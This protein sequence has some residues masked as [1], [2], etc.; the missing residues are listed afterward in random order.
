MSNNCFI[1]FKNKKIEFIFENLEPSYNEIF[2]SLIFELSVRIENNDDHLEIRAINVEANVSLNEGSEEFFVGYTKSS[3]LHKWRDKSRLSLKMNID[4]Y[5]LS[6]IEKKR[7]GKDLSFNLGIQFYAFD[8]DINNIGFYNRAISYI[9]IPQSTWINKIL[10]KLNYK[11]VVLIELPK[12]EFPQLSMIIEQFDETWKKYSSNNID[13]TLT[14]CRKILEYVSTYIRKKGFK[15]KKE[16]EENGIKTKKTVT[17]WNKFFNDDLKGDVIGTLFQ[18]IIGFNS[19][20]A[21]SSNI[22][23][24]PN[25]AYFSLIQTHALVYYIISQLKIRE[26]NH[27][28]K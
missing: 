14:N 8:E 2:P 25:N 20:G 28:I 4:H 19:R 15:T 6:Q 3:Y 11:D 18:K 16:V 22:L 12:L 9:E 7:N 21:H 24:Q 10:S 27:H 1:E 23:F 17:D 5:I 26:S 13:D